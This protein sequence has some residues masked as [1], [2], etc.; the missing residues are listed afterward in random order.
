[1]SKNK[2]S[3]YNDGVVLLYREKPRQTNFSA[4]QNVSTIDDLEFIVKLDFEEVSKRQ[5]DIE[6]AEQMDF[7][8][9]LK[10]KTPYCKDVNNKCKAVIDGYLY[11]VSHI[12]KTKNE[13]WLYL[14]EVKK[15][16]S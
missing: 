4:H 15:L 3:K 8:L 6:F 1:M 16:D 10:V 9:N 11:D 5:Q 2:F 12:D 14:E 7:S 13:M